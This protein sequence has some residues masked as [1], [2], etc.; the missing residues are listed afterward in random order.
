MRLLLKTVQHVHGP[1]EADG[2]NGA[3][4]VSIVVFHN[5]QHSGTRSLFHGFAAGC[6]P[7]N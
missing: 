6:F 3:I 1:T 5:L 2:I 4:G 7:P